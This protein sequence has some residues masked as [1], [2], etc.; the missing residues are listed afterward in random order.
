MYKPVIICGHGEAVRDLPNLSAQAGFNL[1]TPC[2]ALIKPNICGLYHPSPDLLSSI[3][4]FLS[5]HVESLVIGE[6][7]SMIHT[8]ETQFDRLGV[9][10]LVKR[11]GGSARAVDLS[12]D[13]LVKLQVPHPHILKTI[14]LPRTVVNA[15]VLVNVPK[16]G[17]HSETRFTGALKNLFGLLPQKR[18]YSVYHP[19]GVDDVIADIA[20]VI[21]P[22]LNVVDADDKVILGVDALAVDVVAC[23]F[24]DLNPF[25]I[26]HLRRVS[27][28]RAEALESF[29]K[30]VKVIEV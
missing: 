8:P 2:L 9:N 27:Q 12:S 14:D 21:N 7:R 24:V 28:D 20:Q 5:P 3:M 13:E 4:E 25:E 15:D 18:K 26:G 16:V 22:H 1:E 19:L 6:T 10:A 23:R 11:F 29:M 30:R 17:T